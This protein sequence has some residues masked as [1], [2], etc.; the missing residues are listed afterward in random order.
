[1]KRNADVAQVT[2]YIYCPSGALKIGFTRDLFAGFL[3]TLGS[4]ERDHASPKLITGLH[5]T[6]QFP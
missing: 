1:M 6:K 3:M 2:F 5:K 4:R